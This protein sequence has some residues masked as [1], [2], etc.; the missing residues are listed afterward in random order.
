MADIRGRSS[1]PGRSVSADTTAVT[2][3]TT[4]TAAAADDDD[5]DAVGYC[6]SGRDP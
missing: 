6:H 1:V 5:D 3:T 2:T 4:T